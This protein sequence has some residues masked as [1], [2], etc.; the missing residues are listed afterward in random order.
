MKH[1]GKKPNRKQ[2]SARHRLTL[3]EAEAGL[4]AGAEAWA[5]WFEA[6]LEAS[7][8][9]GEPGLRRVVLENGKIRYYEE[10]PTEKELARWA[11][12]KAVILPFKKSSK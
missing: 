8:Q 11:E 2:R 9:R 12:R 4:N 6:S 3:E 10:K 5:K 1:G 7:Y